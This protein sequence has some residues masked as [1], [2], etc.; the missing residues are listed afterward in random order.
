[1]GG[2]QLGDPG[3]RGT[4]LRGESSAG[5]VNP[6][7]QWED[8]RLRTH[9]VPGS[10]RWLWPGVSRVL[11]GHP[12]GTLGEAP[13]GRAD[14]QLYFLSR[15]ASKAKY[16]TR[17]SCPSPGTWGRGLA[18]HKGLGSRDFLRRVRVGVMQTEA[19]AG[20]TAAWRGPRGRIFSGSGAPGARIAWPLCRQGHAV[21][22][23]SFL[24]PLR[25]QLPYGQKPVCSRPPCV[26]FIRAAG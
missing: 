7:G 4:L 26:V 1:M 24:C 21:D 19:D 25:G 20:I 13:G 18:S 3:A 23:I 6:H 11:G 10:G 12:L 15:Q 16:H 22:A 17:M 2:V 9:T 5:H 14:Q 8:I